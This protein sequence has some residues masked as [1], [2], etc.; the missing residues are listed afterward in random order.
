MHFNFI[1]FYIKW[2]ICNNNRL[3]KRDNQF[4]TLT[5][6]NPLVKIDL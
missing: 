5:H 6:K 1:I 3:M 4:L 2:K